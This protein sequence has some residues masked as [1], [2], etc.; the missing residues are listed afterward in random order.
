MRKRR[1]TISVKTAPNVVDKSLELFDCSPLKNVKPDRILQIGEKKISKVTNTFSKAVAIAL[2][3][4]TLG[5]S[6]DCLNCCRLVELIKEKLAITEDRGEI[7]QLLTIVP[8]DL[9]I[10]KVVEVF[11]VPEYT[12]RQACELRLRK[13]ILSM[14]EQKQR[15]GFH[16]M[17]VKK[18]VVYC[19][20]RKI[21]L[22]FDFQI[23]Q[24]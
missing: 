11:K 6:T 19:H 13:G 10:S 20:A 12:A 21:V 23:K 9:P 5:Q 22:L 4:P 17:R 18:S 16:F 14:P 15:A 24:R 7:I 2:D 3:E 8:C 1:K